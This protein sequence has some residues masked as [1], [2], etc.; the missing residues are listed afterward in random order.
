MA[1]GE[2]ADSAAGGGGVDS[3]AGGGASVED[4][5][6]ACGLNDVASV[7]KD[8]IPPVAC[9]CIHAP[10]AIKAARTMPT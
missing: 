2:G 8:S 3:V 4:V 10:T 9:T 7:F 6:A 1:G 5:E